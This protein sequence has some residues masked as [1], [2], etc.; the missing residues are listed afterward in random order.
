MEEHI[1]SLVHIHPAIVNKSH[2][3]HYDRRGVVVNNWSAIAISAFLLA[4]IF[5]TKRV[6]GHSRL[7]LRRKVFRS[8]QC[9]N[10]IMQHKLLINIKTQE[11][12]EC[13]ITGNIQTFPARVQ[14][15][16]L[17]KVVLTLFSGLAVKCQVS[18]IE[19]QKEKCIMEYRR[20]SDIHKYMCLC[21]TCIN[22]K[23]CICW[24][25]VVQALLLHC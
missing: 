11:C 6:R 4:D 14:I 2:R 7:V 1:I 8:A 3:G 10:S 23:C 13:L 9:E 5:F 21:K 16:Q 20:K 22:E 24:C 25:T 17:G 19:R 18:D 15:H 12:T